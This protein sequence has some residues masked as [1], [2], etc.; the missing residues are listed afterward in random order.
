MRTIAHPQSDRG[1]DLYETPPAATR[2]L[3]KVEALPQII[4]E[5]ASGRGAICKVLR[6][7]GHS[8]IASD[9]T[10]YDFGLDF[11]SDFLAQKKTPPGCETILTNPPYQRAILNKFIR[12]ALDLA[13]HVAMLLR[14]PFLESVERTDIIE[15]RG[16]ARVHIFRD[17]LPMMHRDG[18][19]GP[20]A[21]NAVA[22]GWF[23]WNRT[24]VG[25]PTLHRISCKKSAAPEQTLLPL[26]SG[27]DS[28]RP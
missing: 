2:A 25:P 24:H 1:N 17:R 8:V 9:I 23:V 26:L 5:P 27:K 13:P 21:T 6:E 4:W 20:R 15:N 16:L 22:F 7:F 12:H 11:V 3:L 14:L 19:E 28:P 10:Q 18:W